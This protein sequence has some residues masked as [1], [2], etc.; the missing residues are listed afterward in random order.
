MTLQEA[1]IKAKMSA[2][3]HESAYL[4]D[5]VDFGD[6]WGFAFSPYAPDVPAGGG[7]FTMVNKKTEEIGSYRPQDDYCELLNKAK[8][9]PLKRLEGLIRPVEK[10]KKKQ[11]RAP[12]V[13]VAS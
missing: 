9:I 6:L 2:K 7:D 5:C 4:V 1:Y 12:A 8:S 10:A 3:W 13:A 11:E